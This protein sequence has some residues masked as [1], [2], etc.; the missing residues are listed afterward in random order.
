MTRDFD[1]YYAK[2]S[3]PRRA[4]RDD[5]AESGRIYDLLDAYAGGIPALLRHHVDTLG[6]PWL[7]AKVATRAPLTQLERNTVATVLGVGDGYL[8]GRADMFGTELLN[9]RHPAIPPL[10]T[11]GDRGSGRKL[12]KLLG[13]DAQA[14]LKLTG[15]LLADATQA[16]EVFAG[17]RAIGFVPFVQTL[18]ACLK[19]GRK[20]P[21][22][23][24]LLGITI[25]REASLPY[26][27]RPAATARTTHGPASIPLWREPRPKRV[28]PAVETAAEPEPVALPEPVMIPEEET[29]ALEPPRYM[30]RMD[31]LA[32][33]LDGSIEARRAFG[34]Y[35]QGELGKRGMTWSEAAARLGYTSRGQF[36]KLLH[37]SGYWR[38]AALLEL[39][40]VLEVDATALAKASGLPDTTP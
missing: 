35:I 10:F 11:V 2:S 33:V 25:G 32:A 3:Q 19:D 5:A 31:E 14:L 8:Q 23:G 38:P 28:T 24:R 18:T 6:I 12:A 40:K 30:D 15:P 21:H 27:P 34:L 36:I 16:R 17:L 1:P 22:I 4:G 20:P 37:G 7:F 29:G 13:G 9:S 39:P 26:L